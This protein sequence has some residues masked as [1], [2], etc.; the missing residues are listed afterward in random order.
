MIDSHT[1]RNQQDQVFNGLDE[2]QTGG[3]M[4]SHQGVLNKDTAL[5][6]DVRL[7]ADTL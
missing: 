6:L 7:F 4:D 2:K 3:N 5:P 1:G